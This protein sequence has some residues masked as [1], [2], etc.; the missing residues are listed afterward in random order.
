MA[1][2]QLQKKGLLLHQAGVRELLQPMDR[3]ALTDPAIQV[4]YNQVIDQIL[5]LSAYQPRKMKKGDPR[6]QLSRQMQA[7]AR[8]LISQ[9]GPEAIPALV[10]GIN[11]GARYNLG[12]C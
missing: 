4:Q 12:F 11:L 9:M 10:R 7:Q 3:R 1:H 5:M 2:L 6:L 8:D